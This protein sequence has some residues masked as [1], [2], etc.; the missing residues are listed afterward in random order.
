MPLMAHLREL[1]HRFFVAVGAISIATVGGWFLYPWAFDI[2]QNPVRE[3]AASGT[4]ATV[5]GLNFSGVATSFDMQLKVSL[6]IGIIVACPVWLYQLWGFVTPGLTRSERKYAMSYL[7]AAIPLFL[8]GVYFGWVVM[9]SAVRVLSDFV[10]DGAYNLIDVNSYFTFVISIV[11][12]CGVVFILPVVMVGLNFAGLVTG[13][14][15]LAGWRWAVFLAFLFAAIA[16][17]SGDALTMTVL[18]VPMVALFFLA[19]GVSV[20]HDRRRRRRSEREA[21]ELKE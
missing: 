21:L 6:F 11:L 5:V 18:A 2:L 8:G 19:V 4:S 14:R 3:A 12:T 17:P 13:R 20:L 16:S 10:P 15:W 7:A 9:P 1:R